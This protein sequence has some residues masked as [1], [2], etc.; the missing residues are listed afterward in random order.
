MNNAKIVQMVITQLDVYQIYAR[1]HFEDN[2]KNRLAGGNCSIHPGFVV[3]IRGKNIEFRR[4]LIEM[5]RSVRSGPVQ[6][7]APLH[8]VS[9]VT[10]TK[11]RK[12]HVKIRSSVD[13]CVTMKPTYSHACMRA[14]KLAATP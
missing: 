8:N 10:Q 4:A 13:A 6:S 9:H 11:E 5:V 14:R 7:F 1:C 12:F 3:P 2:C